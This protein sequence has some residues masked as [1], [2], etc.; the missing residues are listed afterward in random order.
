M[1]KAVLYARC[2]TEEEKQKN[3]LEHQ[4]EEARAEVR[5]NG[6]LLV[7][8]YVELESGTTTQKRSQ[9]NRLFGDLLTDKFDV[10]VIKSQDRLM[11]NTKDWYIFVDRLSSSGKKLFIY[12][13][14]KF[15]TPD[16]ALI[17]GI[18]AIL[19]EEYSRELSKKINNAHQRRQAQGGN[20][21]L[22]SNTYGYRKRPD[23]SIEIVEDEAR[24]K[25]R[26]YE[27]CAAGYGCRSIANILKNEGIANK[28][29]NPFSDADI[30]RMIRNPLNKGTVVMHREHFDFATKRIIKIPEDQQFIYPNKV[31]AIVSEELWNMANAQISRRSIHKKSGDDKDSSIGKNP[32][33]SMLSG[34]IYCGLCGAPYYRRVR[35]RYKNGEKI[36]EWKC[37]RYLEDG[38]SAGSKMRPQLRKIPAEHVQGC[39]N[40]H[41]DETRFVKV[42]EK[43]CA[44]RY[45]TNKDII[46]KKTVKLLKQ[47]L[48]QSDH[49]QEL[50]A[51][52]SR[53]EK[54][55][56][57]LS[58]L[59]DKLLDGV[60]SDALYQ[61][62][63]DAME[64]DLASVRENI[65][66][67][68]M[69]TANERHIQDRIAQ[70]ESQL[71]NGSLIEQATVA[72]MLQE[73][74]RIYVYPGYMEIAFDISKM[75]DLGSSAG[76]GEDHQ[77][78]NVL[79]VDYGNAFDYY[80][81]KAE[82][83]ELILQM[84]KKQPEITAKGIAKALG[85]SLSGAN[86]CIRALKKEGKIY[87]NGKGGKGQWVVNEV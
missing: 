4:V 19:A 60:I 1:L 82:K 85:M 15:Y 24:V 69:Q 18:K 3:A 35:H 50:K 38:R 77:N 66:Q 13:E 53:A 42:L 34:K 8:E 63:K 86:Y 25:R 37:R 11:R 7:D 56:Q 39:D 84:M 48:Q 28:R 12:M 41:L 81:Q 47:A 45:I 72:Q 52:E 2:S 62:K 33:V 71:N 73:I 68:Q 16:D 31:P 36:Y 80:G 22:T 6:W 44:S 55:K 32:G 70:I 61:E 43:V 9:Y 46:I 67:I 5:K 14:S 23:K 51:L 54:L 79:R 30:L 26:M 76:Y 17:T 83:R 87:F 78:E 27:L 40:I 64:K 59:T 65:R 74:E 10:I 20:V 29:G 75:L 57:R 49:D 58:V 21:I